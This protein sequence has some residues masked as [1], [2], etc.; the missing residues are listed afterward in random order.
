MDFNDLSYKKTYVALHNSCNQSLKEGN[1]NSY[2]DET[3][4]CKNCNTPLFS[5]KNKLASR[6]GWF[7]FANAIPGKIRHQPV[8]E[9]IR[10][11]I[12]CNCCGTFL[13][14]IFFSERLSSNG[15]RYFINALSVKIKNKNPETV[16]QTAWLAGGSF[17]GIEYYLKKLNGVLYTTVGYMGGEIENPTYKQVCTQTTGHYETVEIQYEPRKL[18][19]EKLL[20][21][22][23]EIH[24]FSQTNGQN[25]DIGPQYRSAIFWSTP[26]E[27]D[28]AIK[29]MKRLSQMG[30]KVATQL[31]L[32]T[33]FWPAENYHQDYYMH[34][35]DQPHSH[36]YHKIF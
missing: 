17:W 10:S 12:F 26:E 1:D 3:Y 4:N 32:A 22:F 14:Y 13:G 24:D 34:K 7:S 23:F 20:K 36:K 8:T 31:L 21:Y 35:Q 30:F 28:I 27:K 16:I 11:E 19:Y 18:S 9:N 25:S 2:E 29:L 5:L 15:F 6:I 33:K